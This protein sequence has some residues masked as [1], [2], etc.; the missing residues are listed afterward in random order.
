MTKI[1]KSNKREIV[2]NIKEYTQDELAD[3]M[4]EGVIT[5]EDVYIGT[6]IEKIWNS[7]DKEWPRA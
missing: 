3:L 6:M 1:S 7:D 4:E 5:L 2:S